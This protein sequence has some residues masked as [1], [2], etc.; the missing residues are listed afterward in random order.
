MNMIYS[1]NMK[2]ELQMKSHENDNI[3]IERSL[4]H[5]LLRLHDEGF[6]KVMF[7]DPELQDYYDDCNFLC[8]DKELEHSLHRLMNDDL[9]VK[10]INDTFASY[11]HVCQYTDGIHLAY[12]LTLI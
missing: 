12:V 4:Y 2:K 10:K 6:K 8:D 9:I 3:I 1:K 5:L 11:T 7:R